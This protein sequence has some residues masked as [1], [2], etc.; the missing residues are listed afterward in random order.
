MV[1]STELSLVKL[2]ETGKR[3][4]IRISY[5]TAN[6]PAGF[7]CLIPHTFAAECDISMSK[8]I[9]K[10]ALLVP[11]DLTSPATAQNEALANLEH[12]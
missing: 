3:Y 7:V 5:D 2:N 8:L 4:V 12:T 11:Y 6:A 1:S 9:T 10:F